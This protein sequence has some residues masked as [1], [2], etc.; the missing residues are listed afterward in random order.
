M[1]IAD[2]NVKRNEGGAGLKS[3]NTKED[4]NSCP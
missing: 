1:R 4:A 3:Y 2:K